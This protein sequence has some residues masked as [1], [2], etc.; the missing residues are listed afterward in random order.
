MELI[1]STKIMDEFVE[2]YL[3]ERLT[4]NE[5]SVLILLPNSLKQTIAEIFPL[6]KTE[7]EN[8]SL[9]LAYFKNNKINPDEFNKISPIS[10]K[11]NKNIN[12]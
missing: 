4:D 3:L 5:E 12:F 2:R 11:D 9:G 8:Y 6:L 7:L 1:K 10:K